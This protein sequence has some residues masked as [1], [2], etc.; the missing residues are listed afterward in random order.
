MS[1]DR[2]CESEARLAEEVAE[3]MRQAERVDAEEDAVHGADDRG[4]DLQGEMARRESR[5]AKIRKAKADLE[6]H[7]K[8]LAAQKAR[9]KAGKTAETRRRPRGGP[10]RPRPRKRRRSAT[11]PNRTVGS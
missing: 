1:Y 8:D 6:Q 5:L 2:M 4:S 3:M 7:A 10:R 11:S 9:A